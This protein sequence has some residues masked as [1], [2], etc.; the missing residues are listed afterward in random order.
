MCWSCGMSVDYP[1]RLLIIRWRQ[2]ATGLRT[3]SPPIPEYLPQGKF[4]PSALHQAPGTRVWLEVRS[5]G[6]QGSG[7]TAP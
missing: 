2:V 4:I 6:T 7:A 1:L 5:V 3:W